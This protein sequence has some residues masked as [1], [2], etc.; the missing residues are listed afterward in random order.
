MEINKLSERLLSEG[1]NED[2]TPPNCKPWNKFYGG[3]TYNYRMIWDWVF[4]T[5]CGLLLEQ[6]EMWHDLTMSYGGVHWTQENDCAAI[7]CPHYSYAANCELNHPLLKNLKAGCHYENLRFCAVKRSNRCYCYEESVQRIRDLA[8]EEEEA[9]WNVFLERHKGRVCRYQSRY[10]RSTKQWSV[11]YSPERCINYYDVCQFCAILQKEIEPKKGNVF[12]DLKS[13]WIEKG[14]GLFPD[15]E[16]VSIQK[17]KKY[18]DSSQSLTICNAIVRYGRK[19]A[20]DRIISK[21]SRVLS[22][23][24]TLQL[25]VMNIRAASRDTRDILQDLRDASEGIEVSHSADER[26]VAKAQK[27]ARREAAR[28]KTTERME[29]L[30]LEGGWESLKP[31][32]KRRVEKFLDDDRI[33][34]LLEQ[35]L[36]QQETEQ[37][38]FE[39]LDLFGGVV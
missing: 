33:S 23:R 31:Y 26:K 34:E 10:D 3:W 36:R 21:H 7:L 15:R 39:Q 32:E 19:Y 17:G 25:E 29:K 12:Y 27:Q 5:P 16:R 20:E 11:H 28:K 38:D 2:Q 18:L 24:M 9:L 30:I 6:R 14:E 1:W 22:S 4:E 35:R 8:H 13:T 37:S